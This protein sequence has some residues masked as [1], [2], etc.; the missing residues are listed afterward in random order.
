MVVAFH[1]DLPVAPGGFLGVDVF[2]VVS[3]YLITGLLVREFAATGCISLLEFYAR[4]IRR[5]LPASALMLIVTM[6]VG[7]VVLAPNEMLFMA[8]AARANAV[9]ASNFFFAWGAADYFSPAIEVNPLLHTW[10]LAVEEQFFF[11][12]PAILLLC[13]RRCR[14]RSALRA[15]LASLS[16]A[17]LIGSLALHNRLGT[18]AFYGLPSRVWQFGGGAL[19]Y[20][21]PP[22]RIRF[23]ERAWIALGWAGMAAIVGSAVLLTPRMTCPSWGAA[24]V[25]LG[26]IAALL[27]GAERPDRGSTRLLATAPLQQIGKLSYS[28]YLWHWPFVVYAQA[29]LP[30][31]SWYGKSAASLSALLA[32][33]LTYRWI[34]SPV[35]FNPTL[36]REPRLSIAL[37]AA[38]AVASFAISLQT[39]HFAGRLAKLPE[40]R[41]IMAAIHDIGR[42]SRGRCVSS[43]DDTDVKSCD[44]GDVRGDDANSA[45]RRFSRDAVVQSAAAHRR[46]STVATDDVREVWLPLH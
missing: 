19:A 28:W 35:R 10:S 45:L 38:L 25:V 3:G 34:E 18:L 9:Y 24:I 11:F 31:I 22:P 16:V 43:P 1:C 42:L 41:G 23:P 40:M 29:L 8:Q 14:S 26:T 46:A 32:S 5:L 27:A 17:S 2:F 39:A 4:R 15:I 30:N 6:L 37:G 44:F 33:F 36:V 13:L 7:A 21:S 12:W 20:L